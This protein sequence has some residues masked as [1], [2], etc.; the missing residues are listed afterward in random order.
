MEWIKAGKA[1]FKGAADATFDVAKFVGKHQDKISAATRTAVEVTGST[2]A[3]AG[4]VTAKVGRAATKGMKAQAAKSDNALVKTAAQAAAL[5]G[6][7]V[8]LTGGGVRATGDLTARAGSAV[9]VATGGFALGGASIASELLDSVALGQRD[10]DDLRNEIGQ[11]GERI[12]AESER[13]EQ[14]IE[15]AQNGRRRAEVLDLWVVGG[16]SLA[17]VLDHPE[18]V[19]PEVLRAFNLAYP[20]LA[21][22]ESFA[23]VVERLPTDSLPGFVS[24][25]KGK[26]FEIELVEHFNHGGLPDGL[27][28]DLAGAANQPGWDI[29]ILDDHGQ[30]VD[31]LQAKAT[32]SAQYVIDALHRYPGIDIVSTSEVHAQLLAMGMAEH[33]TN[34]GI[35]EVSLQAA[36][37]HAANG[38]GAHFSASDLMPSALGLAVISL[39]LMLDKNMSWTERA[40]QLGSRGARAG[41]AGAVAKVAMVVAQTWWIGLVAGVGSHWLATKGRVR[42]EQY[43][44]LREAADLLRRRYHGSEGVQA[45]SA[46]A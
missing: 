32:E 20:D 46:P 39:S 23:D 44:A 16:V 34:S 42:R 8:E 19:P 9:G 6:K 17:Y 14:R 41:A 25:V 7:G 4:S 15:S 31:V 35:N 37:D 33:V 1:V 45:L 36:V 28:A 40:S 29:R 18:D 43:E 3:A 30:V 12:R 2:V 26:L 38:L 27:H 24:G 21:A 11:Y 13:L 5:L 22:H 10:I